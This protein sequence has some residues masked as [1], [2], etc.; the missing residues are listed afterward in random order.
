M[1]P[2]SKSLNS[3]SG[4][5]FSPPSIVK[6]ALGD[7]GVLM[8]DDEFEQSQQ[9]PNQVV[10]HVGRAPGGAPTANANYYYYN[11]IA[12]NHTPSH[13]TNTKMPILGTIL[14][15]KV[16]TATAKM[17]KATQPNNGHPQAFN[18]YADEN[19][20][21]SY[22]F[23][24]S[25]LAGTGPAG[26]SGNGGG[27]HHFGHSAVVH[28]S[29]P[30]H[31]ASAVAGGGTSPPQSFTRTFGFNRTNLM[32]HPTAAADVASTNTAAAAAA[33]TTA[34]PLQSA[35]H[36][37]GGGGGGSASDVCRFQIRS[38]SAEQLSSQ[39]LCGGGGSQMAAF[40]PLLPLRSGGGGG[41]ECS[42]FADENSSS[43]NYVD[44]AMTF[45]SYDLND[46]YWLNFE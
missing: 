40:R 11:Q 5:L 45:K 27:S 38:L 16:H 13:N 1:F 42:P 19:D 23:Q 35:G 14:K 6:T 2:Q 20:V 37:G 12:N 39:P 28:T 41:S 25:K 43:S 34:L 18:P 7:S 8:H 3:D 30:T 17:P 44:D 36:I 26:P 9:Q 29:T 46:E 31:A 33:C 15:S 32:W 10:T 22:H 21:P 4:V 24:L